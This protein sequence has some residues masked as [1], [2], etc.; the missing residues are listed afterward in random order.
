M[1]VVGLIALALGAPAVVAVLLAAPP[2]VASL[3]MLA[4]G[5][6]NA[7]HEWMHVYQLTLIEQAFQEGKIDSAYDFAMRNSAKLENIHKYLVS[8][9]TG[10]VLEE[11]KNDI[12]TLITSEES[13]RT[14]PEAAKEEVTEEAPTVEPETADGLRAVDPIQR[15]TPD[16]EYFSF[17]GWR[18]WGRASVNNES[19]GFKI[20]I[21]VT[22]ENVE[23]VL[24]IILPILRKH[25]VP[26]KVRASIEALRNLNE[27]DWAT[28]RGKGITIYAAEV[29]NP[30]NKVAMLLAREKARSLAKEIDRALRGKGLSV[31]ADVISTWSKD[32]KSG[33]K[34][35]GRSGLMA[36]RFGKFSGNEELVDVNGN[37]HSDNRE[38]HKPEEGFEGVTM[39]ALPGIDTD[40]TLLPD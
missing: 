2:I 16:S 35:F 30:G 6:N 33:D 32:G 10:R 40:T 11:I 29:N 22:P 31:P 36:W 3:A 25:N 21:A 13:T 18:F 1:P 5:Q 23:Q 20:H 8:P 4:L 19:Q 26:H 24:T 28:Q 27:T 39:S 12:L 38:R 37:G 14:K 15:L 17:G 34:I 9:I 7:K